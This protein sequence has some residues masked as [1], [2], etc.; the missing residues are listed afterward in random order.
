MQGHNWNRLSVAIAEKSCSLRLVV[1]SLP[2]E[3]LELIIAILDSFIHG[4]Q[5]PSNHLRAF[6]CA[7]THKGGTKPTTEGG[8][9]AA[10]AATR[11]L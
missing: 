4:S 9:A 5:Q 2:F 11:T 3:D 7:R 8:A 1:F 10:V 6:V